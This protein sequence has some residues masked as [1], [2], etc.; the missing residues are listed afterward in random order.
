MLIDTHSHLFSEE[1]DE[2]RLMAVDRAKKVG[3]KA[4]LLPNIDVSTIDRLNSFVKIDS[5]FLFPMMGLHPTSINSAYKS[6]LTRIKEELHRE[7][8]Q[9]IA[10]G[11]VGLDLYWDKT[12]QKEQMY[13]FEEQVKW[14]IELD[15]PLVIHCRDAFKPLFF[16]LDKYRNEKI[17]GVFHSFTGSEEELDYALSYSEFYVGIN[18][19][20]TFKNS[21]ELRDIVS[22]KLPLSRLLLETDSPYLTPVPYRGKR[23][24]SSFLPS[25][26][27]TMAN[28]YELPEET[29][30]L[31]TYQNTVRLF[32][33]LVL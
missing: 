31:K 21:K 15:L 12:Y 6:D 14:S 22:K 16:I 2:D 9:Y 4:I 7:E 8:N 5:T 3:L 18:G 1:F 25:V 30:I 17:R 32:D 20:I 29:V 27:K 11:E 19:I 33:R 28:I 23:N 26:A 10:V 13:A 24:E